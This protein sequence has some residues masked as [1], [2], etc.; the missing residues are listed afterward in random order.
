MSLDKIPENYNVEVGDKRN[1][2]LKKREAFFAELDAVQSP[3]ELAVVLE[4]YAYP[5][6][7]GNLATPVFMQET[8]DYAQTVPHDGLWVVDMTI[9]LEDTLRALDDYKQGHLSEQQLYNALGS[10]QNAINVMIKITGVEWDTEIQSKLFR[11]ELPPRG[12]EGET[13][14]GESQELPKPIE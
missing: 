13:I 10:E 9:S 5:D 3:D 1:E 12:G 11:G 8:A 4:K 6:W 7:E 14:E 2:A